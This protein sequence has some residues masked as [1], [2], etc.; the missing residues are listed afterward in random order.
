MFGAMGNQPTTPTYDVAVIGGGS[1]GYAAAR[2]TAE[3]GL[4]TVI[5]DGA[6]E[7]GG[8]CILRG[9]M[10][11][12][13]LIYAAEVLHLAR[14]G[15]VWGLK[16]T[17][18]GFDYD[19]LLAR[20]DKV[21]AEFADYRREQLEN[22][23]FQLLRAHARFVDPHTLQLSDGSRLIA[24]HFIIAT[25]SVTAPSPL[26]QLD[27]VGY[28]TSDEA[29]HLRPIPDS[30][31]VLGGGPIAIE[32]AQFFARLDVQVTVIQR[33][34]C[35]LKD[36][37]PDAAA[38]VERALVRDGIA[39]HTGTRL[40]DA[41]RDGNRK[42][43]VFEQ[44]GQTLTASASEIL[45]A[46]GRKPNTAGLDL[47]AAGVRFKNDRVWADAGMRTSVPHIFA[48]GDC[49][50]PHEI[51][52]VAIRQAETAARNIAHPDSPRTMDE[53]LLINVIFSDPQVGTVGLT[54]KAARAAGRPCL[55]ASYPFA[56]HGKSIIMDVR[57]GFVKLLAD[58][59]TGEILGGCCAG[60]MG[61]EL[62]H[63]IVVAMAARMTVRQFAALP[64]Y[65]PTLAEIWTYPAEELAGKIPAL[66]DF[67]VA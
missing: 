53:R 65:H 37:D 36:L 1:A 9:C 21:I 40:L 56:D 23:P 58:P 33:S 55:S 2:I 14:Q 51:V 57:D 3:S 45:F 59:R 35:I 27:Q 28:Q 38:V 52:H 54:E 17:G 25:G 41:R 46:L 5:V 11:T 61:G 50:G 7:L 32:F 39:L 20:K 48:A 4:K 60:P 15:P 64:H 6:S 49:T 16:S 24:R 66:G 31:V 13:A 47:A 67:G 43:V 18:V 34:E 44:A 26:P 42:T 22:G 19:A 30:L 10:P 12:K 63:E 29:I 8:L 62:I